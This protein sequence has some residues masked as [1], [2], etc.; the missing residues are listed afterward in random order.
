MNEKLTS[1]PGSPHVSTFLPY[2][3]LLMLLGWGGFFYLGQYT[4]P[5][6]GTRWALYFCLTLAFT[7]TALPITAYLNTRFPSIPPATSSVVVREALWV[8][9]YF[10]TLGWLQYSRVFTMAVA[11]ILALGLVIIEWLL[12]LR[13][14]AQYKP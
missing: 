14:K 11:L 5:S 3:I 2:A 4:E 12:R 7:G 13:E 1:Q 9:I 8:G 10:P 6:G